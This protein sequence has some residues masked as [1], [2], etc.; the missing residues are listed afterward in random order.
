MKLKTKVK[1]L[2]LPLYNCR[3]CPA[4]LKRGSR[5]RIIVVICAPIPQCHRAHP[6]AGVLGLAIHAPTD[7]FIPHGYFH[8]TRACHRCTIYAGPS[9]EF[10]TVDAMDKYV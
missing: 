3:S 1:V 9:F 6:L 2:L 8:P 4:D 7:D 5:R 10:G